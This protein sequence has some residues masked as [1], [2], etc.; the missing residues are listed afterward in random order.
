MIS[1]TKRSSINLLLTAVTAIFLTSSVH[2]FAREIASYGSSPLKADW[3]KSLNQKVFDNQLTQS[4]YYFILDGSG[5]MEGGKCT[6]NSSKMATAKSALKQFITQTL[7]AQANA[8]LLAFDASGLSERVSIAPQQQL[9]LINAIDTIRAG[10]GTPLATSISLA[11]KALEQQ[12][13]AQLGYG[14]YN[15]VIITDGVADDSS[16]LKKAI[17]KVIQETP[18]GINTIGFCLG[19]KHILNRPGYTNYTSAESPQALS[20]ALESVSAA[21]SCFT[22]TQFTSDQQ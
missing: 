22:V 8:G 18:I 15:I 9:S 4:N 10:S 21:K 12:A 17:N 3:P 13:S 1:K 20:A 6:Q 16:K 5:S 19:E 14:E 11:R 2:A 7:P